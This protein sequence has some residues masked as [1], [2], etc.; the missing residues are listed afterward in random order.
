MSTEGHSPLD[1]SSFPSLLNNN[2]AWPSLTSV[3]L[4]VYESPYFSILDPEGLA[5]RM[6]RQSAPF[7]ASNNSSDPAP[8]SPSDP[9]TCYV[10]DHGGK[11]TMISMISRLRRPLC[12]L[13]RLFDDHHCTCIL[14]VP[15]DIDLF[16]GAS[17]RMEPLRWTLSDPP[18]GVT[19]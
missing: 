3:R 15:E 17:F 4:F 2:V 16:R 5:A 14:L 13:M 19:Q 1:H 6:E 10:K 18:R 9:I 7:T 12:C 8:L 11:R